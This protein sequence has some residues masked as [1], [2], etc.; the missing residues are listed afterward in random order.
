MKNEYEI[1]SK[2]RGSVDESVNNP[3]KSIGEEKMRTK[4]RYQ[5]SP[6]QKAKNKLGKEY[7]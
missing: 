3:E 6:A 1:K 7:M 4:L 2:R 5:T